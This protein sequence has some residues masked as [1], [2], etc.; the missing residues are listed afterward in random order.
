MADKV[1]ITW[2][3]QARSRN[4]AKALDLDIK[5][6]FQ[7]RNVFV[8]HLFSSIWTIKILIKDKPKVIFIQY[9]YLLLLILY[10]YKKLTGRKKIL[11]VDCHTKALRRRAWGLLNI[12]F[13]PMKKLSFN[14]ADL[15]IISNNGLVEDINKLH[16]NFMVLPDMI[17][18][19]ELKESDLSPE[20]DYYVYI[21]SFAVD[22]PVDEMLKV[23]KLLDSNCRLFWTGKITR[24][25]KAVS[26]NYPNIFFTGYLSF[27]EYYKLIRNA[28]CII[29]LTTEE[30]CLQ[31][32]A[33]EA[34]AVEVP[35]VLSDTISL[36]EFFSS[37]AIYTKNESGSIYY[38]I[39]RAVSQ[40]ESLKTE[41]K[42]FKIRRNGEFEQKITRILDIINSHPNLPRQVD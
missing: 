16:G 25:I 5:E 17:P 8:R 31:S 22:E 29:A 12:I 42:K 26:A 38:A 30:D 9:S 36:R 13:W 11:I 1:W 23:S 24:D 7:N 3:F 21:S 2:H 14:A 10:V 35:L 39:N 32:G 33:Y 37:T 18:R 28:K 41:M 20:T 4:L 27:D 19:I 6:Y 15:T 34:V 40:E